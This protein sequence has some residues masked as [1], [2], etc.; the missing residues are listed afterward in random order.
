MTQR[1]QQDSTMT[2]LDHGMD[3][4]S[5][6]RLLVLASVKIADLPFLLRFLDHSREMNHTLGLF[7]GFAEASNFAWSWEN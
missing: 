4:S 5:R 6:S 7:S 1:T 3:Q 2:C